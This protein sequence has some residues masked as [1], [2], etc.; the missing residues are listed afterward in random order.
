MKLPKDLQELMVSFSSEASANLKTMK[1]ALLKLKK[2]PSNKEQLK[3]LGGKAHSMKGMTA[4][5]VSELSDK[6]IKIKNIDNKNIENNSVILMAS[7][8]NKMFLLSHFIESITDKLA[9]DIIPSDKKVIETIKKTV[10]TMSK[11]LI[12]IKNDNKEGELWEIEISDIIKEL[13]HYV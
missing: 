2:D 3:I 1:N 5:M 12:D 9:E 10:D 6:L 8:I 4:L 11:K 7:A 13:N